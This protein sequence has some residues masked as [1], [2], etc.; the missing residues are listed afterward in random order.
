MLQ[1]WT[2]LRWNHPDPLLPLPS[3]PLSLG[4]SAAPG[5]LSVLSSST[6]SSMG[7]WRL[8]WYLELPLVHHKPC[9]ICGLTQPDAHPG[10]MESIRQ[11]SHVHPP[12]AKELWQDT[13]SFLLPSFLTAMAP[14]RLTACVLSWILGGRAATSVLSRGVVRKGIHWLEETILFI[15]CQ[16]LS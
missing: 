14:H 9:G 6:V 4:P 7:C 8:T 5:P 10:H 16:S 11:S 15:S 1:P 13:G 12:R 3:L 2:T